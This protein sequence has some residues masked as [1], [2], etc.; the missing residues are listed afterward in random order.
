MAVPKVV[1]FQNGS[2]LKK[3]KNWPMYSSSV[4]CE[5]LAGGGSAMN[6]NTG[7]NV[8]QSSG[9]MYGLQV[10]GLDIVKYSFQMHAANMA[11]GESST[12]RTSALKCQRT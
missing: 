10:S 8:W 2:Q 11:T 9:I 1:S 3:L 7:K 12:C 4:C 6:R 5:A